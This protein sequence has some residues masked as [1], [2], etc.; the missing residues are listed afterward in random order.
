MLAA[1]GDRP[2]EGTIDAVGKPVELHA[3]Y[4]RGMMD[5]CARRRA[6]G[7]DLSVGNGQAASSAA[8]IGPKSAALRLA[9]TAVAEVAQTRP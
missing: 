6:P 7:S 2:G 3:E 8:M 5:V 9:P 4:T 1:S